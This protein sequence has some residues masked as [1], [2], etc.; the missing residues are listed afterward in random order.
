MASLVIQ[1]RTRQVGCSSGVSTLAVMA[2]G[3]AVCLAVA[4]ALGQISWR[5]T[6]DRGLAAIGAASIEATAQTEAALGHRHVLARFGGPVGPETRAAMTAAGME[7]LVYVGDNSFFAAI[8]TEQLDLAALGRVGQ[9]RGVQPIEREFKLHPA[10]VR[11]EVPSW[12]VVGTT[13]GTGPTPAEDVVAAYV[14]FHRDVT[15]DTEGLAL[16]RVH[17]AAVQSLMRTINGAVV[18]LP[19]SQIEALVAEDAVEWIEPPLP[20]LSPVNDGNRA[21][22][23]AGPAQGPPYNLDGSGV[24]VLVYDAGTGRDTHVDFQGRLHVH[25]DSGMMDHSTHV[26]GTIGGAGIANPT[27]KGMAPGVTI[28]AYGFQQ[29]GGLHPGFLYTDPGDLEADYNEAINTYGAN[30]SS[31]SIASNVEANGYDCSWQ[32]DY[33]ATSALIDAIVRGSLGQPFRIVWAGGNERGGSRCDVEGYGDYY[34][35]PPPCGAK[36]HIAVGALNSNDDSMTSFSSWGPTDDGRLKPDLSAP[37]CQSNGDMGVTSCSSAGDTAYTT[38]C[39]TSMASPTV[40]G[41]CA[42]LLQDYRA[43]FPA[44]ADPRNSTLKILLAHNAVDLGNPGPDYQFGY[45]SIPIRDTIDF[46]RTGSFLEGS[47]DQGGTYVLYVPVGDGDPTMKATLAWDDVAAAPSVTNALVNDL[48]LRV[49]DP[50]GNR[51]YPW[52]LDPWNPDAPAVQWNEDHTNNIEQVQVEWPAAGVWRIEVYGYNVPQGPQPFSLC[53]SPALTTCSSQGY[54]LLDAAR[55]NCNG[56]VA[57]RVVDCDLNTNDSV[58]NTVTVAVTSWTEPD[59]EP[60]VL[61][62]TGPATADFRGSIALSTTDSPGVLQVADWDT[63]TA[64]YL[65]ANDGQGG[66]NVEVDVSATVDC[67]GPWIGSVGVSDIVLSGATVT[68]YTDELANAT[69]HYGPSCDSL[70]NSASDIGY[71]TDHAIVLSGLPIDGS[72][73]YFSLEA[74]DLVGNLATDDNGGACYSFTTLLGPHPVYSWNL[75]TNPGWTAQGQWAFGVPLG[76]CG[77]PS[78]GHTGT[79]IYGYNLAGCYGGMFEEDLTTTAIDCSNVTQTSL[80]FW[81]WLGVESASWDHAQISVSTDN[82]NWTGIWGNWMG[83]NIIDSAWTQQEYDISAVADNQPTVYVRWAM[84]PTDNYQ[85]FCGW[86]IDDVEIWGVAPITTGSCCQTDGTCTETLQLDCAGTWSAG[87]TCSPNR[88]LQPDPTPPSPNPMTFAA[89][90]APDGTTS[91]SM[92]ASTAV[93]TMSPPVSYHFNL[94]YGGSGGNDSSWQWGTV[95]TDDGLT[96]NT[97]YT[98]RVKARDSASPT[99]NETGWSGNVPT[100]TMIE[101]PGYISFG[102]VTVNSITMTT[103]GTFTNLTAGS[104]GVYFD[105]TTTGGNGGIDSWVQTTSDTATGLTPN[106]GYAFR[107]KARNLNALETSYTPTYPVATLIETPTGVTISVPTLTTLD[108]TAGGTFSNLSA[109]QSGIYFDS[110]T[111]GGNGGI[112]AWI[113]TTSD[114]ATGLT[115]N[116]GYTFQAKA[117]NRNGVETPYSLTGAG[118]TLIQ[119]P[120][121]IMVGTI[122]TNTID[123]IATGTFTNLTTG[124]SG[125]YFDSTTTGGD[126]GINAWVQATSDQAA[127][128][129]PNTGYTFQVKARN[130]SG[131]ETAYSPTSLRTTLIET[132]TGVSFGTVTD[133][134]IGLNAMGT[135]TNLG[136]GSSGVYFD[137]TTTGGDGGI[138]AWQQMTT[139]TATG[140]LPNTNY[141]FQVKARNQI[142]VETPYSPTAAKVTLAAVPPAP[143]LASPTPTTMTVN[144]NPANNPTATVFAIRCTATSPSDSAWLNKYVSAAGL[145]SASAVWQTDATWGV[146]TVTG[147]QPNTTYTFAVKARNGENVETAFGAGASLATTSSSGSGACCYDSAPCAVVSPAV[148]SAGGGTYQGDGTTCVLHAC[149]P[150]MGDMNGDGTVNGSD[151][152]GFVNALL[153]GFDP[154]ADLAA[155]Y[156][157]LDMADVAAFVGQLLGS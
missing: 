84:G 15:L 66:Q 2:A 43:H 23:Q 139:D 58:V 148:C 36:N 19:Y 140:L 16:C 102:T 57:I 27:Y 114:Q 138:N 18:E 137:S 109:G 155:P 68:F 98:Y 70:F 69:V 152:Q 89:A 55:Y 85:G 134:S 111:A 63:I 145:A 79:T 25:D 78:S 117:R 33:G 50:W 130:Q 62:E 123:L 87:G 61:T 51:Y 154:C 106:T 112:N 124:S 4:P 49:F 1:R 132:P 95:Y 126:G 24:T 105:S 146:V 31:N 17:G 73:I 28:E 133:H 71:N 53:A 141:T 144:V 156:G 99:P 77:D 22:T 121:G 116:T 127:G 94:V 96:P 157:T 151:I 113:Q 72:Q 82:I 93:D 75:D 54:I 8:S 91:I 67:Q 129:T 60:V 88:C 39:G 13:D 142:S 38:Y 136:L 5:S 41:C 122:A 90:P 150:L 37:G 21:L 135:L 52:T 76:Q 34:S 32:G 103:N 46:M 83:S 3:V 59:G 120:T 30:I 6:T 104:S 64:H 128:L 115:P 131:V 119:T 14:V 153:A 143:T 56:T 81:R 35:V 74:T 97:A 147:L 45:G 65:D 10:L 44:L 101:W 107:V 149:C 92:T 47:V 7:L 20:P 125:L 118:A 110:T 26:A 11:G 12:A 108:L 29:P 80:K 42:L 48:D 9:L 100:A 40:A 86:N